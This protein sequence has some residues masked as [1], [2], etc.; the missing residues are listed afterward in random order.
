ME[1]W[2]VAAVT[3]GNNEPKLDRRL[4][5]FNLFC[6]SALSK[7]KDYYLWD[8]Q[9]NHQGKQ[10]HRTSDTSQQTKQKKYPTDP[11]TTLELQNPSYDI[12]AL[13][14]FRRPPN[15]EALNL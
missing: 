11:F 9:E 12:Q 5:I 15:S 8:L 14:K 1:T 4:P 2:K 7:K 13:H 6:R 10:N 3:G